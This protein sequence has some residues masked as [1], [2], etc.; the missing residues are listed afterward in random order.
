M[1][2]PSVRLQIFCTDVGSM[3]GELI[4]FSVARTTPLVA[5]MPRDV[6]WRV[7]SAR[8]A[9]SYEGAW[10]RRQAAG[11]GA[12][13]APSARAARRWVRTELSSLPTARTR[14]APACPRARMSSASRSTPIRPSWIHCGGFSTG[15][16]TAFCFDSPAEPAASRVRSWL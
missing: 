12:P 16:E 15:T 6:L 14:S 4:F 13:L 9:V 7:G 11:G 10:D 2:A 3:S 5:L 1:P 8:R